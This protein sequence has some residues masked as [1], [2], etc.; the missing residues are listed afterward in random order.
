MFFGYNV[1]EYMNNK[2]SKAAKHNVKLMGTLEQRFEVSCKDRVRQGMRRERVVQECIL[3]GD[4]TASCTCH[5]PKLLHLPCSHVIAACIES[6]VFRATFVSPYFKK[7]TIVAVWA[8]EVYGI[9]ILGPFTQ[10]QPP[11]LYVPDPDR[12]RAGPGRRQTR[13]IRNAMDESEAARV[14]TRCSQ[15]NGYGHNYKKCPMNEVHAAAEAG[16]SGNPAD[17]RAPEFQSS[18][19][20]RPR[21]RRSVSS[22]SAPV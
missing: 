8:Q 20:S 4:G 2:I 3:R 15:C 12:K 1:T 22:R 19:G 5:K 13:R 7:E 6:A 9:G 18:T 21:P 16:P 10:N 14:E 11:I 17:G